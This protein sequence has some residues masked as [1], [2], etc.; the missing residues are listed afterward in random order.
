MSKEIGL[1]PMQLSAILSKRS[2]IHQERVN[3]G[4]CE[5]MIKE[6]RAKALQHLRSLH[7]TMDEIQSVM[8]PTQLAKFY[9]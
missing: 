8:S 2:A 7:Q 5:A 4:Q 3:M 1:T 6:L 9:L